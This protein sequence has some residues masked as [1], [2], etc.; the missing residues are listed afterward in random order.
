[1]QMTAWGLAACL[2]AGLTVS[3]W[4][5]DLKA[6]QRT[7]E[8]QIGFDPGGNY[9]NYVLNVTGP[10]GFHARAASQ[11]GTPSIDLRRFGAYDDGVYNY[12]LTASSD[13]KVTLR[14][15]LDDG[16]ATR[17]DAMLKGV[18]MSG[19]FEVKGGAIVKHDLTAREPVARQK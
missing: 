14:S 19:Q 7:S 12:H 16:R 17:A 1:M 9:N 6:T 3:C 18:A 2:A 11:T 5:E 15:A 8:T 10:H 13:E 4:A